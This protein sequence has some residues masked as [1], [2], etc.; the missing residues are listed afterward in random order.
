MSFRITG[1]DPAQFAPFAAMD[2]AELERHRGRRTTAAEYP[3]YP[4]RVTLDDAQ[5]G[6]EVLLL[7]FEHL[8]VDSPYRSSHAIYVRAGATRPYEGV[9]E[10]PPALARRLLSVRAFDAAGLMVSGEIL[11]GRD[12]APYVEAQLANQGV[13]YLHAHYARRGCFA[14]RIDRA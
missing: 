1:L 4:C 5:P 11:E 2:D 14:A 8:P 13:A 7:N 9:D 12:L 10:V 3:G 6:E